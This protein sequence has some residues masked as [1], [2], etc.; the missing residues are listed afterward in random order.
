MSDSIFYLTMA[1][2]CLQVLV[3]VAFY[4]KAYQRLFFTSGTSNLIPMLL[5]LLFF[6][7]GYPI[8]YIAGWA[9]CASLGLPRIMIF[10][11]LEMIIMVGEMTVLL[12]IPS[13]RSGMLDVI[14]SIASAIIMSLL[15]IAGLKAEYQLDRC[16]RMALTEPTEEN[17]QRVA[18]LG[19]IV[20]P[21]L[22][23]LLSSQFAPIRLIAVRCLGSMGPPAIPLLQSSLTD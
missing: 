16:V 5:F 21:Y 2:M 15:G 13:D 12:N 8:T 18:A 6:K 14:I 4:F 19:P 3:L 10:W 1:A 20:L 9:R 11:T 17:I 7:L 23:R 22:E